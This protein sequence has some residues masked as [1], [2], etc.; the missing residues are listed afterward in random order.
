VEVL[1]RGAEAW[2]ELPSLSCGGRFA[3]RAIAVEESGSVEG[4]VCI[5]GGMDEELVALHDVYIVDLATGVCTP[6]PH[7]GIPRVDF[8]SVRLP[9]GRIISAGGWHSGYALAS[10]EVWEPSSSVWRP[11]PGMGTRRC[12]SSGCLMSGSR[13]AFFGGLGGDLADGSLGILGSCQALVLDNGAERWEPL[14]PMLEARAD[15]ACAAVGG[16]V[17]IAGGRAGDNTG[18]SST[19]VY[20]EAAGLW[21]RLPCD[22]PHA[23]SNMGSVQL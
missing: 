15:F 16:C 4:Q 7:L 8:A 6:Q 22:L 9:G 14:P 5:L 12:G 13:V 18:L 17:I 1:E 20:E 10:A 3:F 23:L 11:L 19:E 21:R 2:R